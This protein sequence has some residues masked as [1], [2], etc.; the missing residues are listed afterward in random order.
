[1]NTNDINHAD[2]IADI[3]DSL[4]DVMEEY[5]LTDEDILGDIGPI[6]EE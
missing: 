6:D 2:I 1:M 5:G 3:I 4:L